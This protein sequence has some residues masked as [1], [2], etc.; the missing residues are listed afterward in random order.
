MLDPA[1]RAPYLLAQLIKHGSVPPPNFPLPEPWLRVY[2][3][4]ARCRGDKIARQQAFMFAVRD[5]PDG[6]DMFIAVR[7]ASLPPAESLRPERLVHDADEALPVPPPIDWF[8]QCLFTRPSLNLLVGAPG[9]KKTYS[10]LD[11]AV[12]VA[13]GQDWLGRPTHASPVLVVDE[14]TGYSRMLSRLHATLHAHQAPSGTLLHFICMGAYDLR[15]RSETEELAEQARSYAAGLIIIDA[16]VDVIAG[17]DENSVLSIYP[18][19]ANLR[20][21]SEVCNAAVLLI[22]H[23]NKSGIF[24]GS[25]S[26]AGAVDLMLAVESET[27]EALVHFR[28][29]KARTAL[30]LPFTARAHFQSAGA[31]VQGRF[32]LAP[33]D[34]LPAPKLAHQQLSAGSAILEF[35]HQNGQA[36][37]AQLMTQLDAGAAATIRAAIYQ[38]MAQG[39]VNRTDGGTRGQTAIFR[40]SDKGR[41]YL[42]T[43]KEL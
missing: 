27:G 37:S 41:H 14:E 42:H 39:L 17:G 19:L 31:G 36:T 24:R 12:C 9:T 33:T 11:L 21:L 40:L 13:L 20:H 25:S 3:A 22:H 10:A 43:V 1:S 15:H 29:L 30:P 26:I 8:V 28:P 5:L 23:T 2:D 34:E 18:V 32:W 4:V 35:L 38:L 16:L 6:N 7:T